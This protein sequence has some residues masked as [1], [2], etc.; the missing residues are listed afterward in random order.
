[1][2]REI[3]ITTC[4]KILWQCVNAHC[5]FLSLAAATWFWGSCKHSL[6]TLP[7]VNA[8]GFLIH[9]L[10]FKRCVLAAIL[11][12]FNRAIAPIDQLNSQ[13]PQ[14]A[15]LQKRTLDTSK[16]VRVCPTLLDWN[17]LLIFWWECVDSLAL[18]YKVFATLLFALK[19]LSGSR[20][21]M[22][23]ATMAPLHN[24][25]PWELQPCLLYQKAVL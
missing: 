16:R 11:K 8:R 7:G 23:A 13:P 5:K 14:R 17:K 6:L 22:I 12:L 3:A 2:P 25:P 24:R 21:P 10:T 18:F 4:P 19:K 9:R 15:Y 1:M 20:V